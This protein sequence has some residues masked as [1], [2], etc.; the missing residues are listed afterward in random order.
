MKKIGFI[1][2][3]I[4]EW[5]ANNYPKFIRESS[6]KD[7]FDVT[8]AWD[9][10]KKE[11]KKPID[12]WCKEQNVKQASSI[13]QV[14]DECDCIVVLSPDNSEMHEELADLPLRSGKPVYIDKPIA[15]DLAAAKRL[16]K[17]AEKFKTPM[18]SSS[19]LRFGS[20]L[21]KLVQDIGT[22][23]VNYAAIQGGGIFH[24]YAI[25]QLEMLVMLMGPGAKKVMQSGGKNSNLMIVD[26]G[27]GRRGTINL[28]P[29]H[30]FRLS[31]SYGE[32]KCAV[33]NEMP[34][35][36][37]RFI[38]AMLNFFNT[39]KSLIPVKQTLE[40]AAL[41]GAG[42]KALETPDKWVKCSSI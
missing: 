42:T 38:E 6:L 28:M 26:Y 15:P 25:H 19:A 11:G 20:A 3:F 16:F 35:F 29:G 8:L 31:T 33:I 27:N 40:I 9:M 17:K 5:H 14:I 30:G 32:N 22:S 7:Q 13:K 10:I 36:F 23:P 24:I 12:V 18:M 41:I 1:D 21:E 39:K 4:D 2:Y 37:P 34:D